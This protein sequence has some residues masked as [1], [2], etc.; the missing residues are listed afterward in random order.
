MQI[1][2]LSAACAIVGR[3]MSRVFY[4]SFGL[5]RLLI[6]VS[7]SDSAQKIKFGINKNPTDRVR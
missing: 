4:L 1:D 3:K 7:G 2:Q 5:E 6:S